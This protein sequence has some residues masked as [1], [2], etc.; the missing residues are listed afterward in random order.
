MRSSLRRLPGEQARDD[1][2]ELDGAAVSVGIS[3][4]IGTARG[5]EAP[6][7]VY[8]RLVREADDDMY[9]DKARRRPDAR[10]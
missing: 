8:E 1:P 2:L 3:I 4:G 9:A 10:R 7:E 6:D 5:G